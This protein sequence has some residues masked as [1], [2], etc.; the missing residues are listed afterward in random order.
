MDPSA[1]EHL[2]TANISAE[3]VFIQTS[4]GIFG[5][6]VGLAI[7]YPFLRP[8]FLLAGLVLWVVYL[9]TVEKK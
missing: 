1:L 9:R 2:L 7:L 4:G 6:L 3:L 8:V 5:F